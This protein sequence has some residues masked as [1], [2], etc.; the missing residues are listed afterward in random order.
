MSELAD[1]APLRNGDTTLFVTGA[2][3]GSTTLVVPSASWVAADLLPLAAGRRLV[4]YDLRGRGRSEPVAPEEV[5]TRAG[6]EHD[7]SDLAAVQDA[8]GEGPIDLL[9]W[10]YHGLLAARYA[11]ASPGRVRRLVL[12]GPSG[13]RRSPWYERFLDR[14]GRTIDFERLAGLE[15]LKRSGLRTTDPA[16]YARAVHDV[17]FRAYVVDPSV[18]AT[19]RSDPAVP[20]NIDADRVNDMG[21]RVLEGLGDYDWRAEF[22]ALT[23][24]VLIV[25][26]EEDP[27]D[28]DGSEEWLEALPAARLERWPGVGHM[29]WLERPDE[30]FAT[31]SAFLDA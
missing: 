22:A 18:L 12:V 4:A 21:R 11:L 16:R 20:P 23:L 27:V 25:H 3:S 28:P 19:M 17:F 24:P 5:G 9:G 30:F 8:L 15:E 6:L 31:V 7:L 14:F 29:P 1:L 2:G 13:P 10:S 26:G